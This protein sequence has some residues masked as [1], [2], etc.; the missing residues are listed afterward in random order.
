MQTPDKYRGFCFMDEEKLSGVE[1]IKRYVLNPKC[2]VHM[3]YQKKLL[4]DERKRFRKIIE[5]IRSRNMRS[6][7]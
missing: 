3:Q 4:E 6:G 2:D 7:V 5:E 1:W